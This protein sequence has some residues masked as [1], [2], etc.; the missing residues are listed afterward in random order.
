MVA[1]FALWTAVNAAAG[2]ASTPCAA[3]SVEG[4]GG[5]P[6]WFDRLTT[7]PGMP[8]AWGRSLHHAG[9][10]ALFLAPFGHEA[11]PRALVP[12]RVEPEGKPCPRFAGEDRR[13]CGSAG[14]PLPASG[15]TGCA[16]RRGFSP[17]AVVRSS[18]E[19]LASPVFRGWSAGS[20]ERSIPPSVVPVAY[21]YLR[22][23]NDSA[24]AP[25]HEGD[26]R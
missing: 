20:G 24:G 25:S 4:G 22:P 19:A 14:R 8:G 10:L 23:A 12:R 3:I 7:K 17:R 11:Q 1:P 21:P 6:P 16:I 13:A 2:A 9:V 18:G 26:G 5:M 15:G